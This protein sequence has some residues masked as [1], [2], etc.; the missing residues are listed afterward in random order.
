MIR[1]DR[2]LPKRTVTVRVLDN[3][4]PLPDLVLARQPVAGEEAAAAALAY[5][6]EHATP[7]RWE[8]TARAAYRAIVAHD[9]AAMIGGRPVSH[10]TYG[11]GLADL[12]ARMQGK[13]SAIDRALAR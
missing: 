10:P 3:K 6:D 7:T 2:A 4:G 8:A 5:A 12:R 1:D 11:L 13:P 9:G